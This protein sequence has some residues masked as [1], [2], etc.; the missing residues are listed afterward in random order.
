MAVPSIVR[1]KAEELG[2]PGLDWLDGL[3]DLVTEME[4]RWSITVGRPIG[5][6]TTS[7]VAHARTEDGRD[8]VLKLSLPHVWSPHEIQRL[9]AA[10]GR[11][12][13]EL[14]ASDRERSAMLLEALGPS[15]SRLDLPPEHSIGILCRTLRQAWEVDPSQSAPTQ[16]GDAKARGLAEL[17]ERAWAALDRPCSRGVIDTALRYAERREAAHRED[18]CVPVHGD[19]HPGN[20]MR[21]HEPRLGAESGFVFVDPEAFV[22]EPAYDLGV[23]LRE[24]TAELLKGDTASMAREYCGLLARCS[25][26]DGSAIWE[27]GFLERVASGLYVLELGAEWGRDYLEVAERLQRT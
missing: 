23:V 3:P 11:G 1:A 7:Y 21:V 14:L 2:G 15:M 22:A 27:W 24:W 4:Q 17:I 8:A 25:G 20:A 13:A 19:P 6:G 18:Q 10:G 5:G 9:E 26:V 12:Y 16:A